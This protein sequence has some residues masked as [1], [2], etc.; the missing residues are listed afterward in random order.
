MCW[1]GRHRP[2]QGAGH[3]QCH[4]TE[5]K[6]VENDS[7]CQE[8]RGTSAG[9]STAQSARSSEGKGWAGKRAHRRK[10]GLGRKR[11]RG[12][13][14]WRPPRGCMQVPSVG[15]V[16]HG[17]TQNCRA[18]S[19]LLLLLRE[20]LSLAEH[21]E[22]W[23]SFGSAQAACGLTWAAG[24]PTPGAPLGPLPFTAA[25]PFTPPAAAA[26]AFCS[27]YSRS[28]LARLQREGGQRGQQQAIEQSD[29]QGR[30]A[31]QPCHHVL[32]PVSYCHC[33]ARSWLVPPA[34]TPLDRAQPCGNDTS[35]ERGDERHGGGDGAQQQQHRLRQPRATCAWGGA[36]QGEV[37]A[38]T[39]P[40]CTT[41]VPCAHHRPA[42]QCDTP[43]PCRHATQ[44]HLIC[45]S[46]CL[47]GPPPPCP[48]S[49]PRGSSQCTP[50]PGNGRGGNAR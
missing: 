15:V 38:I 42:S 26:A 19:V 7:R 40:S 20:L 5:W 28:C 48:C 47:A 43:P 12:T 4:A 22:F 29:V 3:G 33:N 32:L 11:G 35:E 1:A 39:G 31:R 24:A 14:R 6:T 9:S 25:L 44:A 34:C 37:V 27:S 13:N 10:F 36:G 18:A 49:S 17:A 41:Q 45:R 16:I 23:G 2:A 8:K 50:G 46:G 21:R 30:Q